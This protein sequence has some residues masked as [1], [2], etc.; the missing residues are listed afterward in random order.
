MDH[1]SEIILTDNHQ[2]VDV[3]I[4]DVSGR[5]LKRDY[6]TE[7]RYV[8]EKG[9]FTTGVYFVQVLRGKESTSI[10]LLVK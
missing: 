6:F 8:I 4:M 3:Y 9:N 10:K 5:L 2:R 7:D 1:Y